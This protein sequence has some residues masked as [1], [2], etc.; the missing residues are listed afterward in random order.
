MNN[1]IVIS[2]RTI[3]ITLLFAVGGYV[4]Y[5]LF[6]IF[7]TILIAMFIVIALEPAVRYFMKTTFWNRLIPRNVAVLITYS[8]FILVLVLLFT[9]GLPPIL[10]QSQKL[11]LNL[12]QI[13]QDINLPQG[14]NISLAEIFPSVSS[15]SGGVISIT[16]AVFSNITALFS[17]FILSVYM[18]LDWENIK[19]R[20]LELLP[21]KLEEEVSNIIT[22]IETNVSYWVKG[23]LFLMLIVGILSFIGLEILGIKFSLALALVS[24]L[25][26]VVP[27][28]GPILSAVVAS[29]IGFGDSA[30]KGFGVIALYIVIQQ[31]ENNILVPKIMEKV[32]GFSP[33]AI[34]LAL[35][36]GS[37]FFGIVGAILAVPITMV[38]AIIIKRILRYNV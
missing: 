1:Q 18:S 26:E 36:I 11:V 14:M 37:E 22:E 21:D 3:V 13:L 35:L 31:M 34:L 2:I 10:S 25:L 30:V 19:K 28:I 32:S 29:I 7:G 24:G 15:V 38:L 6:P 27:I 5:R 20:L 12:S 9:L 8:L 17:L 23:E 33:L 4:I 16:V